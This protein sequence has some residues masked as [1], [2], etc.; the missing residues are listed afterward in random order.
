MK[1]GSLIRN[2]VFQKQFISGLGIFFILLSIVGYIIFSITYRIIYH[3]SAQYYEKML[4]EAKNNIDGRFDDVNNLNLQ[5]LTSSW[6][7]K[8]A[9]MKVNIDKERIDHYDLLRNYEELANYNSLNNFIEEI[10]IYFKNSNTIISQHGLDDPDLFF[11]SVH[12]IGYVNQKN[13]YNLTQNPADR[14]NIIPDIKLKWYEKSYDA[15]MHI[16][17]SELKYLNA[18]IV[19]IMK[20]EKLDAIIHAVN[21]NSFVLDEKNRLIAGE[22]DETNKKLQNYQS[23]K[24]KNGS[25]HKKIN[26]KNYIVFYSSSDLN[27]WKYVSPVPVQSIFTEALYVRNVFISLMLVS[28][29]FAS[30]FYFI[31]TKKTLDPI[32]KTV[33]NAIKISGVKNEGEDFNLNLV[34]EAFRKLTLEME[35]METK[36]EQYK[37][38]LRNSLLQKLLKVDLDDDRVC[39]LLKDHDILYN[40]KYFQIA[41]IEVVCAEND[42]T[43]NKTTE[44]M[45][46]INETLSA[47]FNMIGVYR[48][49]FEY[50]G[51]KI[52]QII[53]TDNMQFL[54]EKTGAYD[55]LNNLKSNVETG[56]KNVN[57]SVAI[58]DI[59]SGNSSIRQ[60]FAEAEK[61]LEYNELMGKK[62][63]ILYCDLEERNEFSY[64]YPVDLESRLIQSLQDGNYSRVSCYLDEI[65]EEN[66]SKRKIDFYVAKCLFYELKATA[67]KAIEKVQLHVINNREITNEMS[68]IT[69]FDEMIVYIRELYRYICGVME[70]KKISMSKEIIAGI[71]DDIN[72]EYENY[73]LSLEYIAQKHNIPK[74]SLSRLFKEQTGLF[75]S[76]YIN[77]KRVDKAKLLLETSDMAI[78]DI[79]SAVGYGNDVTFRRIFKKHELVTPGEY[80]EN[81]NKEAE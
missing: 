44:I 14:E 53:N 23:Y 64:Y 13:I 62:D 67:L 6:F 59:H 77:K 52:V 10:F 80:R 34:N 2:K 72:R 20:K 22:S 32:Q 65:V 63:V 68:K 39:K 30:I 73:N 9:Y 49:M 60:S 28:I 71:I 78:N 24:N 70:E 29:S 51:N 58:G 40:F 76:D 57:I 56:Y 21:G 35:I 47:I 66:F 75:F 26:N 19:T 15:V 36:I 61:A 4:E 54:K 50:E 27:P 7:K 48:Q 18:S 16:K 37:P 43:R 79:A 74:S 3:Q 12:Q 33:S 8:I 46:L 55:I 69:T 38:V 41:V 31:L 81:I 17:N 42:I 25:F 45:L 1:F 11:N 5:L